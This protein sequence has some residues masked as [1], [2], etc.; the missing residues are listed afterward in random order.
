MPHERGS[1]RFR[2]IFLSEA[3]KVRRCPRPFVAESLGDPFAYTFEGIAPDRSG[4]TGWIA[5]LQEELR[6]TLLY[7]S[8][9]PFIHV[10]E[11][12]KDRAKSGRNDRL[13]VLFPEEQ[14]F[15]I[16]T[17]SALA[18]QVCKPLRRQVFA[19]GT[20][21]E[22]DS[23]IGLLIE[24]RPYQECCAVFAIPLREQLLDI[25]AIAM[26]HGIRNKDLLTTTQGH[27][28]GKS[29]CSLMRPVPIET[30]YAISILITLPEAHLDVFPHHIETGTESLLAVPLREQFK[31]V[32]W[33]RVIH[34]LA[35]KI[36]GIEEAVQVFKAM[37]LCEDRDLL[38][39]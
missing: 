19:S 31:Q 5:A 27:S 21:M 28:G 37:G 25:E 30:K 35:D 20:V 23:P 9:D 26:L 16:A 33:T 36:Q 12:R 22:A 34:G 4:E 14:G 24:D 1:N 17:R 11:P 18:Q 7:E 29:L 38:A 32:S 2:Q 15:D 39:T 8:A 10:D 3:R 13:T 6:R